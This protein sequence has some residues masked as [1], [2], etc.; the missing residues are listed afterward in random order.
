MKT[1]IRKKTFRNMNILMLVMMVFTCF[2]SWAGEDWKQAIGA[3]SWTFPRDHGAHP[4]F[5]TEWWYFTGNLIDEMGNRYGYQLTF[6]RQG[7][8]REASVP[9][10]PWSLRDV[11][12]AHFAITNVAGR[13]FIYKDHISRAGPGLA[14]AETGKMSVWNLNWFAR[15]DGEKISIAARHGDAELALML[16]PRKSLVLHDQNG[17]S[18]KGPRP[19][20]ASYYYSFTDLE[21][22]GQLK[23]HHIKRLISV[24]GTSWFDHEFA[25]NSLAQDQ[26]GWD[27][28]SLHFSDGRDLMIYLLRKTDGSVETASSGTLVEPGGSAR[29]LSLSEIK[30]S[31]S[32]YWTSL[33]TRG[34]YPNRWQID[35]PSANISFSLSPLLQ[36]QELI[37]SGSTG[38]NY[39]EGA[40]E[41]RGISRGKKVKCE[42][43]IEMTGY[44]ESIGGLF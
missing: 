7:I 37:T 19:G 33:K 26:A 30:I 8:R 6:F 43:Y 20:Q 27:W 16:R 5:K 12:P 22:S 14:G 29:H 15:M 3:R 13:E 34:R 40:V 32:S 31:I 39:Y 1:M 38:V 10:N 2:P 35:I 41:G 44:A 28:F 9:S 23:T 18:R 17:L 25:S 36:D 11:Y 4:E 24:R 42:G 21:T